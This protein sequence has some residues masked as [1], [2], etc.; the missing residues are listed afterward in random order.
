MEAV[1]GSVF[2]LVRG[3]VLP[4]AV[5]LSYLFISPPTT[6]SLLPV[7]VVCIGFYFGTTD[8]L[9]IGGPYGLTIG[10]LSSFFA[11]LDLTMTKMTLDQYSIYDILYVTNLSTVC[12]TIPMIYFGTEYSDHLLIAGMTHVEE[13]QLHSFLYKALVCGVL[14]YVSAILALIQLD[15]TSPTTHQITTSAR[16]VLQTVLSVY[17][18]DET[19]AMPQIISILVILG[20]SIGYTLVKESEHRKTLFSSPV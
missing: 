16:G 20:G 3:L 9:S 5:G 11:A 13:H 14:T 19:I 12:A 10:V 2:N 4:F 18:L 17:Y 15:I 1:D 8:S 6:L 7:T